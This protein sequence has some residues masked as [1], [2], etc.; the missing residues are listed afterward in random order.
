MENILARAHAREAYFW[1]THAGAELDLL[2]FHQGKRIGFE[3]KYADAP[4]MTKS[5]HTA[6]ADL[7]LDRAWVVYPGRER[8][9]LH[10]KVEAIPLIDRLEALAAADS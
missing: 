9:R 8:Y 5:L 7:S 6:L 3:F 4:G 2:L 1:A 10:D